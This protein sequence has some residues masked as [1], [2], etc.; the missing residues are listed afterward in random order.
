[1]KLS[2]AGMSLL[3][4]LASV[5]LVGCGGGGSQDPVSE[6]PL[7]KEIAEVEIPYSRAG[8]TSRVGDLLYM[9]VQTD[10]D[11]GREDTIVAFDFR[12]QREEV[13]LESENQIE[14]LRVND[15]WIVWES[16]GSL[17]ARPRSGGETTTLASGQSIFA[18]ALEGDVVA[19]MNEME[20]GQYGIVFHDLSKGKTQ[21]VAE[22][23]LPGF[24]NAFVSLSGG[25]LFW[26]DIIGGVGHYRVAHIDE[27]FARGFEPEGILIED[28]QMGRDVRFRYPGYVERVGDHLYSINFDNFVEWD[29]GVQQFGYY[30]TKEETFTPVIKDRAINHHEVAGSKVAVIDDKQHLIIYDAADPSRYENLTE[31][32]GV[33]FDMIYTANENTFAAVAFQEITPEKPS[34]STLYLIE[35]R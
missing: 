29:W 32:L 33:T 35:V 19:W 1:M 34:Y 31:K 9:Q 8:M 30:S 16:D 26:T 13:V 3:L 11:S 6:E 18:P 24:Y 25:K 27:G 12:A 5:A 17:S 14:W 4:G 2:I 21:P 7:Y 23:H 20:E 28:F 22:V 10:P 15:D